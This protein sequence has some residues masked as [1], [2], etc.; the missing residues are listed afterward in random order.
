[1][2]P[3]LGSV[4]SRELGPR[5]N[6][7]PYICVPDYMEA[8]GPG[9]YGAEHAPFVL[10][11]D[12]VQPDF[13]VRDLRLAPGVDGRRLDDRRNILAKIDKIAETPTADRRGAM[14]TYY[15]K[16]YQMI[17][18]P[19]ARKAFDITA[20]S[21]KTRERYGFTTLGQSAL[22]AR[23]LVE[24]GTR[25]VGIDYGSWDTHFSQFPSLKEDLIP[26]ADRAFSALILDLEERGLLDSTLVLMMGE[27][28]R[29]PQINNRA[30]RDHWSMA[31]T[32][33]WAG[34]GV[35]KGQIIGA[36]DDRAAYPT[37]EP[38]GVE[39]VLCTIHRQLGIDATKTYYTPLGRPVPIVNGGRVIPGLV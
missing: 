32:I 20:E 19:D 22:L 5:G 37:T 12:P 3:S 25:F 15:E 26:A 30:G 16:A 36:T 28:G 2:F 24:A 23:R 10:E 35:K 38:Y 31:Q 17:T 21:D 6:I 33:L 29:T 8:G 4:I 39:D 34:G 27:M 9:F 14:N 13:E 18:A 11:T 1:L 7:P